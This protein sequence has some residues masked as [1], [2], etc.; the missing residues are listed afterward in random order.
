MHVSEGRKLKFHEVSGGS[1]KYE[2]MACYC[3]ECISAPLAEPPTP[4]ETSKIVIQK[5]LPAK[6][7]Q[8]SAEKLAVR[9]LPP[10]SETKKR[11]TKTVE[12]QPPAEKREPLAVMQPS[13]V[14]VS[15]QSAKK[16]EV[17]TFG[18]C[19]CKNT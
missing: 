3:P 6:R 13:Q 7:D 2:F 15:E 10:I 16:A 18:P 11:V 5:Q 17:K 14:A 12:K 9:S 19:R 8:K 4:P 1:S